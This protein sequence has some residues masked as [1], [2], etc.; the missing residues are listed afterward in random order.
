MLNNWAETINPSNSKYV[1][2]NNN[3]THSLNAIIPSYFYDFND[4]MK[5]PA[6]LERQIAE[7][8]HDTLVVIMQATRILILL[9]L[10]I[11]IFYRYKKRGKE[12]LYFYWEFSYLALIS[13]LIFP[14]QQ[15]DAR[16]YFVPAGA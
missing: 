16:L 8:H 12:P 3:G 6:N 9:S 5:A 14:H 10:L 7:I 1:F 13:A 4:G 11:L 2:E 15:K